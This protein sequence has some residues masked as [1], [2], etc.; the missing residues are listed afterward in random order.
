MLVAIAA[1]ALTLI[2]SRPLENAQGADTPNARAVRA[3]GAQPAP[4]RVRIGTY[5]GRAIAVAFA[6]TPIHNAQIAELMKQAKEAEAA[7][8]TKRVEELRA[9]GSA[10]QTV[11]H[12]QAF[13]NAQV[14]DILQHVR[15]KLP[16]VA[17]AA[18]V[19]AIVRETDFRDGSVDT[20]D[21]TDR[22]VALFNPNERT[23]KT[24]KEIRGR[25]PMALE[26]VL[27][28]ERQERKPSR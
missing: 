21:V 9:K 13:G 23:L 17:E 15:D 12:L 5:D 1:A 20:V 26:T 28:A 18:G 22:I 4:A 27:I 16:E 11:R 24:V 19:C 7:G 14:D 25:K 3:D 2:W 8:D 10:L 6:P